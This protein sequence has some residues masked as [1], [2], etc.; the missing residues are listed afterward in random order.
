MATFRDLELRHLIALDAVADAGTFGRAAERLGYTQSAVSQQIAALEKLLGEP[1]FDRPGGPRPVEL[2]PLG[3]HLL[4]E[5]RDLLA[6]AAGLWESVDRFRTGEVGRLTIGTFQSASTKVLP[7]IVGEMV[8]RFPDVEIRVVESDVDDV[9]NRGLA[10]GELDLSFVVGTWTGAYESVHLFDDPFVLVARPGDFAPG[11]VPISV[12][13]DAPMVGQNENSCQI[14]NE[15]G[16][17]AA[18]VDP[19]Y[20]FRTNDNGTVTAMVKAG[21]GLAVQPLLCVEPGDPGISLHPLQPPLPDRE[22]AIAW[23]S[24][25]TLSPIAEQFIEIAR[26]VSVELESHLQLVG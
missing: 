5:A 7:R 14:M 12:L 2:T 6:R 17:R 23:R 26:S 24:G 3:E 20:V 25:R 1:V 13:F 19:D 16:L 4:A 10:S 9:L 18:G 8:R 15:Q 11:P 22:V 21:L